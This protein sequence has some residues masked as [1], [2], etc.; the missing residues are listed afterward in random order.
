M[1]AEP[2]RRQTPPLTASWLTAALTIGSLG[3]VAAPLGCLW[4]AA[5]LG[6]TAGLGLA[7]IGCPAVLVIWAAALNRLNGRYLRVSRR[8]APVVEF[9]VTAAVILAVLAVLVW[10]LLLG[11]GG[12]DIPLRTS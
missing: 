3:I 4:L 8:P 6:G 9:G 5:R 12:P 7:A 1:A 2:V 10:M 11:S